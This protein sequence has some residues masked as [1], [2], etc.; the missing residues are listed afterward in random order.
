M[1]KSKQLADNTRYTAEKIKHFVK[2]SHLWGIELRYGNL[3][4]YRVKNKYAMKKIT[5]LLTIIS[6]Y[7]GIIDL[8]AKTI[9]YVKVDGTG[10]G[11]SWGAASSNIQDMINKAVA[12]DEIWVAKGTYYPTKQTDAGDVRSKI[13]VMKDRVHLYGGFAGNEASASSRVKSDRDENGTV[14]AWE[15][16]NETILSGD[17]DGVEDVW[18]KTEV[19]EGDQ[20]NWYWT[21]TGNTGN[22]YQV[23]TCQTLFTNE[24]QLDGFTI[25]GGYNTKNGIGAGIYA[26][27]KLIVT[28][29]TISNNATNYNTNKSCAGGIHNTGTLNNSLIINNAARA[30]SIVTYGGG[31]YNTA[32]G[33][34]H[35]CTVKNNSAN[36]SYSYGGGIYSEGAITSCIIMENASRSTSCYSDFFGGG[37]VCNQ[38]GTVTDC[39]VNNNMSSHG[40]GGISNNMGTVS[41]CTVNNNSI[42]RSVGCSRFEGGG[43]I[44]NYKGTISNCRVNNNSYRYDGGGIVNHEGIIENCIVTGN[45]GRNGCGIY[46]WS[47]TVRK[48]TITGNKGSYGSGI[49][50][51]GIVDDCEVSGNDGTRGAGIYNT[52]TV[53]RCIVSSNSIDNISGRILGTISA[54][55]GG[56]YNDAGTVN[57]CVVYNNSCFARNYLKGYSAYSY[58]GGIY[59]Y[60]GTVNT[61]C[62]SN[63]R[64]SA[65]ASSATAYERGG[66]IYNSGTSSKKANVYC[67][68]VVNNSNDNLYGYGDGYDYA[69]NNITSSFDLTVNFVRPTSFSGAVSTDEQQKAEL[70]QADWR[71][72]STSSYIGTGSTANLPNDIINGTDLAGKPRMR[73]GKIDVGAYAY[74]A[75][76]VFYTITFNT[77]GGSS[78]ASTDVLSGDKITRP[79]DPTRSGYTFG[80]WYKE[81]ACTNAWNF[82]TG[83]VSANL[84][85]YAKWTVAGTITYTVTFNTQGGSTVAAI[86]VNSG[87]KITRPADPT[88]TGYIFGGWH[89]DAACTKAWDFATD[90]VNSNTTLYAKWTEK[91]ENTYTVTFDTKG[92]NAVAAAIANADGKVTRPADP[93]RTGYTFGGWYKE[94]FYTTA[95]NFDTDVVNS[96]ITLYAK[97]TESTTGIELSDKPLAKAY[98]N[99]TDGLFT[100]NFE[101]PGKY[102][103]AIT[104]LAGKALLRQV[105]SDQATQMNI[106]HYPG[107][108]YLLVIDDGKLQSVTKVVK[109]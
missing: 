85:L 106:S 45:S 22:C 4:L 89:I 71:L 18:T 93:T 51:M 21:V 64:I 19:T 29:C 103:V 109:K 80:G 92:G 107:G 33:V 20:K 81:A 88:R 12:G 6:L 97:W 76:L 52:G 65:Y 23:V 1:I 78:I 39:V 14:E 28:N 41:N 48:S 2:N 86:T 74:D 43:G 31:I 63:N 36:S 24:T 82:G 83:T 68:T 100:L 42:D 101:T 59:N 53:N 37:G 54:H 87:Y 84:T 73:N 66:G 67:A 27:G 26:Q 30:T 94:E 17:I 11:T 79:A 58:G 91:S 3:F 61:C 95:W 9:Y 50:N 10:N 77:Q 47:G 72:K 102:H 44:F 16:T 38:S 55:G 35:N 69:Y 34:V 49:Y 70:L 98:P 32:T 62:V 99:P 7:A 25:K 13:F 60:S 96:D 56:I 90:M 75:T 105:I 104:T 15:F 40:G 57:Y 5:L 108:I 8:S 46:N